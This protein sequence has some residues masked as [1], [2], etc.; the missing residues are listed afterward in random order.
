MGDLKIVQNLS[1]KLCV[2]TEL[3]SNKKHPYAVFSVEV[4]RA[5]S[6]NALFAPHTLVTKSHSISVAAPT[7]NF[8]THIDTPTSCD[9]SFAQ[10]EAPSTKDIIDLVDEMCEIL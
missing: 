2:N 8:S 6:H 4:I 5:C 3:N 1:I 7:C 10:T 9:V